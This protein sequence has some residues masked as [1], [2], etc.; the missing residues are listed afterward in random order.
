MKKRT[1]VTSKSEIGRPRQVGKYHSLTKVRV[2]CFWSKFSTFSKVV[3]DTKLGMGMHSH[4]L[5]IK[6]SIL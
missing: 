2:R 4:A 1:Q 5:K 6:K 3:K